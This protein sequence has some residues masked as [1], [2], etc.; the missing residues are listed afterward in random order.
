MIDTSLSGDAPIVAPLGLWLGV[1]GKAS[2]RVLT[3]AARDTGEFGMDL[4]RIRNALSPAQ[5]AA[6]DLDAA[7]RLY[8]GAGGLDEDDAF[9]SWLA[10]QYPQV[11]DSARAPVDTQVEVSMVLPSR[12]A[13]ADAGLTMPDSARTLAD[14]DAP[15]V[16][17]SGTP[18]PAAAPAARAAVPEFHYVLL[19]TAGKGGMGTVHIA[20]DT[21]LLR[22]V[23]LKELS[24][25]ADGSASART[26]FLREVQITAQLDHPN[27][28]PVYSLELAPGGAPAY[29]MKFVEGKTF[30]A[31]LNEAREFF[32]SK[33]MPDETRA[34]PAR[35]EHFLKVCDAMAYAH[36]KGVIH[37]D[38]KPANLMLGRHNEVYVMD[39]GLCRAVRQ[40]DDMPPDK[41]IVA[42][43]ADISGSASETQLGDVVGTPKYMSPEQAQGRNRELDA[44][45]DQCALGLILYE[46][47]TLDAP[48]AGRTAYEVMV[49]AA[50]G[51]RKPVVHAYLGRRI[52]RE[53]VAIIER[54]TA[55][56]PDARYADVAEMAADLRRY[57]RGE[58]VH[59]R[60]DAAWQ[61]AQ[62]WIARHRQ[63]AL[64]AV[65]ATVAFAAIAIGGLLWQNQQ[66]FKAERLREQRL[67]TLTSAVADVSDRVQMRFLQLE[68]GIENLADSV[69]QILVHGRPSEQRYYLASDFADPQRAPEDLKPSAAHAGRI[70]LHWPV[71]IVPADLDASQALLQV[72]KLT[73]LHQFMRDIYLRSARMLQGDN[74]DFY[75]GREIAL[76]EDN[77]PLTAIMIALDNGITG[78]YPGWD[79]LGPGYDARSRPWYT[80]AAGKHGPKWGASYANAATSLVELPLSVPLYDERAQFIGVVSAAFLPDML[81]KSIFQVHPAAAVRALYLLDGDGHILAATG[82]TVAIKHPQPD[83]EVTQTFPLP[84]LLRRV[85]AGQTGVLE[86]TLEGEKVVIAYDEVAPF[87]WSVVAVADA[88]LLLKSSDED[89]PAY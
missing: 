49:N 88:R 29:T 11:F 89:T 20:R 47:V 82:K 33:R 77:S 36:D 37:R 25:E 12:F 65:L 32:E 3:F 1:R 8:R 21:E 72:R 59:A 41:S 52:P 51:K 64:T 81:V 38:L 39:W 43:S 67:L 42:S 17:S 74:V 22:R 61:R 70:S 24:P 44:R 35:I 55:L 53:L 79:G 46:L 48:Y 83:A 31:M 15:T 50:A 45:S 75:S 5:Q 4:Q 86:S 16:I 54:S 71:W 18:S 40:A 80:L 78:R 2:D 7:W 63:A 13:M 9:E 58:A 14:A 68:G 60:P 26:R 6:V 30:H 34:L 66:L 69:A 87:G 73:V 85:K 28:V 84:D 23:A 76:T 56:S 19:G 27:I 62:R 10:G 57:L